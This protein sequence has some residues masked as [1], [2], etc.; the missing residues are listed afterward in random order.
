M[1][2]TKPSTRCPWALR[3]GVTLVTRCIDGAGHLGSSFSRE[4]DGHIG[5]GLEIY[6][7]QR[8]RWFPGDRR[9]FTTERND[10]FSWEVQP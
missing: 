4:G 3:Y 10:R 2:K 5:R 7:F 6:P 1:T 8:V 9:E